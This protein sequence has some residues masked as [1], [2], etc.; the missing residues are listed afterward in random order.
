ML[1]G[2][3]IHGLGVAAL[4]TSDCGV[5]RGYAKGRSISSTLMIHS[6]LD[7]LHLPISESAPV[8]RGTLRLP[9]LSTASLP[10][11]A[12]HRQAQ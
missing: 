12:T 2:A 1:L 8:T 9:R 6:A 5:N 3:G 11:V 10:E 7:S 4:A